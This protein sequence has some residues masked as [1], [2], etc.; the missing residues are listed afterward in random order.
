MEGPWHCPLCAAAPLAIYTTWI[1]LSQLKAPRD[2]I[3]AMVP[4]SHL[5]QEWDSPQSNSQVPGDFN[6]KMKWVIPKTAGYGDIVI[7]N[8]KTV[9]ASSINKSSPRS[10]RCSFDTRLQLL[11]VN[12]AP[13]AKKSRRKSKKKKFMPSPHPANKV[14]R[15]IDDDQENDD[16]EAEQDISEGLNSLKI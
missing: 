10:F 9:H 16:P 3:L 7:F 8:I 1:S 4:Y 14:K 11:P 6:W 15:F 12:I 5:L 2:S 13:I